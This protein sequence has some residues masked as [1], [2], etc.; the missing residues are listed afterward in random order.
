MGDRT[1]FDDLY[2]ELDAPKKTGTA[3][4]ASASFD[5]LY[6]ELDAPDIP[7]ASASFDDLYA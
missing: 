2:A 5:D 7:E 6:A 3:P 1:T 4:G